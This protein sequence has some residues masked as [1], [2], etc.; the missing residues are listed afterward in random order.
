MTQ[1][2]INGYIIFL[3]EILGQGSYGKV[4][5]EK[6]R[7]IVGSRTGPKWTVQSRSLRKS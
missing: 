4:L 7:S 1:K 5:L 3:K 6:H 2:K